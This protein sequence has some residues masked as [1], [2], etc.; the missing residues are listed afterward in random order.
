[1]KVPFINLKAQY[2]NIKSDID[3]AISKVLEGGFY[4]G[5]DIVSKFEKSIADFYKVEH[6]IAVANGYDALYISLKMLGIGPGDEVI[7]SAYTWVATANA[8]SQTGATP[9]FVDIHERDYNLDI[10]QAEDSI[11]DHTK[12][13]IPVHIYG[14]SCDMDDLLDMATNY[15]LKI[16]ED[17]AQGHGAR[18]KKQLVGSFGDAGVLSFY[19]TKQLGAYGDAG[20]ILTDNEDFAEKCRI[21]ARHGIHGDQFVMDGINSRIDTLQAAILQVKLYHLVHWTMERQAIA[22]M[23]MD[24]L[25]D[26]REIVLPDIDKDKEHSFYNFPLLVQKP[27]KLKDFLLDKGIETGTNYKFVLPHLKFFK[28][29]E[30]F[31]VAES[32]SRRVLTL[33]IYPELTE[34]QINYVCEQIKEF[35][36]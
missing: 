10:E 4:I 35:Y 14:Q 11:T 8:I 17:A 21:Y 18:Y 6:A 30:R 19:P 5:T 24:Q 25:A 27:K 15:G 26:I 33:P 31:P 3:D 29:K 1:M 9:V 16:V 36:S 20:C 28:S 22:Q 32:I 34:R 7:T 2:Q 12:A 23:Y 13:I